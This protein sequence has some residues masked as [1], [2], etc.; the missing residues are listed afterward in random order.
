[1]HLHTTGKFGKQKV[2]LQGR[3]DEI[4]VPAIVDPL[5][6][7]VLRVLCDG[8]S[9]QV[10][11]RLRMTNRQTP[12]QACELIALDGVATSTIWD[13]V[14]TFAAPTE[15]EVFVARHG[16]GPL[17]AVEA[18]RLAGDVFGQD[19]R[20]AQQLVADW[21]AGQ[22]VAAV[23][24]TI[25][26]THNAET[27]ISTSNLASSILI[28][29]SAS[30]VFLMLDVVTSDARSP[31]CGFPLADFKALAELHQS[32][33]AAMLAALAAQ[34][35]TLS[36]N[37]LAKAM[38]RHA[39]PTADARRASKAATESATEADGGSE[40]SSRFSWRMGAGGLLCAFGERYPQPATLRP[41]VR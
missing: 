8:Q 26:N 18:L 38:H 4:V 25:K 19:K 41:C 28:G 33:P 32:K 6:A 12:E 3:E 31:L 29:V 30:S 16:R 40:V 5:C 2:R 24:L 36:A 15:C 13:A 27:P 1:L 23:D 11:G 21:R 14:E 7:E 20:Q 34:G 17:N 37:K 39:I 10:Y 22:P 35:I 9:E